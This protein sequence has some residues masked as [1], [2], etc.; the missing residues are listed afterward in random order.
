MQSLKAH[1]IDT[2]A[3]GVHENTNPIINAITLIVSLISLLVFRLASLGILITLNETR[4]LNVFGVNYLLIF[5]LMYN[6][7]LVTAIAPNGITKTVKNSVILNDKLLNVFE[8]KSGPQ[9]VSAPS[10][11]NLP[12]PIK[13]NKD[14][15]SPKAQHMPIT[16]SVVFFV[17]FRI[18]NGLL[19]M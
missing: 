19:I 10:R 4:L 11:T 15:V 8:W 12:Q 3:Y 1:H 2:K 9:L 6:L 7:K 18:F 17:I 14:H 13:G 16:I 5:T